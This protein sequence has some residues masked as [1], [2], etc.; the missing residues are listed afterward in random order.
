MC[1]SIHA[2]DK[3]GDGFE[4]AAQGVWGQAAASRPMLRLGGG[5]SGRQQQPQ[6]Q[7]V[8]GSIADHKFDAC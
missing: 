5:S 7:C 8:H 3:G 6:L 1:Y 2:R 4:Y